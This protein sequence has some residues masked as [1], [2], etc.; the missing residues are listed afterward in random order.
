MSY[1]K[2]IARRH[3][4]YLLRNC[5]YNRRLEERSPFGIPENKGKWGRPRKLTVYNLKQR[6]DRYIKKSK[7]MARRASPE[8]I[9][10][11]LDLKLS[12]N[13]VVRPINKL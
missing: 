2:T 4:S 1:N 9:I 8:T 13:T 12:V 7:D 5:L 6:I 3:T 11:D 10:H